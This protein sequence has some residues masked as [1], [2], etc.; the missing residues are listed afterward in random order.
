MPA[1]A[2][3][4]RL[5]A[6]SVEIEEMLGELRETLDAEAWAQVEGVLARL[7]RMYGVGLQ[8]A[9]EHARANGADGSEFDTALAADDLLGG[10]LVMHGLHPL[11]TEERVARLA[12]VLPQRLGVPPE[13]LVLVWLGDNRVRVLSALGEG[14]DAA[15]RRAFENVAPELTSIDIVAFSNVRKAI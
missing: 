15:L 6:E 2:D 12:E 13:S 11:S 9:L 14:T 10:L 8:R 1:I 4:A 5:K 7:V 3:E